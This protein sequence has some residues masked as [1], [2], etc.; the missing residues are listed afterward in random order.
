[1]TIDPQN[2]QHEDRT[3]QLPPAPTGEPRT[4]EIPPT[5]GAARAVPLPG[6]APTDA[7]APDGSAPPG[8]TGAESARRPRWYQR[9][10]KRTRIGLAAGAA[11][12]VLMLGACG[13][14]VAIGTAVSHE[15][16]GH[17]H[18]RSEGGRWG[19]GQ[20]GRNGKR[21]G[22][23]RNGQRGQNGQM[24]QQAPMGQPGRMGQ[25]GGDA[26]HAESTATV[27]GSTQT[28]V[29]QTGTVTAVSSS[30]I[31]VK[32][33]DGFEATY[34]VPS[35][36]PSGT[37]MPAKGARVRVAATKSGSTATLT[38]IETLPTSAG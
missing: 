16:G 31:T 23:D 9:G 24:G 1:M 14:G 25:M 11:G 3:E 21:G 6:E 28:L 34:A 33:S 37:T 7:P 18:E 19:D 13:T 29:S 10:R 26:L 8:A 20:Q 4:A 12:L 36:A 35:T 38:Q 15:H 5:H 17:G 32:S 22:M 27:N 30:S 2:P